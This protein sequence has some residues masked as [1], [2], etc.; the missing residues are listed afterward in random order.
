MKKLSTGSFLV[1][2]VL[3]LPATAFAQL[4]AFQG[5]W[6]NV[7]PATRGVTRLQIDTS[8]NVTVHAWGKCSPTDCDNG[9]VNGFAYAPNVDSN[10]NSSARA[11]S[12]IF[13]NSGLG[14]AIFIIRPAPGG[15]LQLDVYDRFTDSSNRTAYVG[16]GTFVRDVGPAGP[17]ARV[18]CLTYNVSSLQIVNEGA[19]GWLLTDGSSRM[20]MLASQADAQKA[21]ALAR[22]H[23]AHCFIGRENTRANRKDYIMEWWRGDSGISA[24]ITNED[25]I[26]Y[27]TSGLRIENEGANGWLLTD[28]SSRMQ[29]LDNRSDA[30]QALTVTRLFSRQC[31][32]GR[33]NTRPNRKDFIVQYLR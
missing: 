3:V 25:C 16:S 6:R 4:S 12:A 15:R 27:N 22:S 21:L 28:G 5:N 24:P 9:T 32:I 8:P 10:L 14:E 7:D 11:I 33:N 26:S 19:S 23:R 31:F 17:T 13:S 29:M 1:F 2:L 18:D 20:L 30:E